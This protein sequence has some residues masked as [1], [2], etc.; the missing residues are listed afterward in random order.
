MT[1]TTAYLVALAA[2]NGVIGSDVTAHVRTVVSCGDYLVLA[3]RLL[4]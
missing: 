4:F 1:N 2:R 3:M